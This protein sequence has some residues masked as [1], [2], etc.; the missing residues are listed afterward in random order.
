MFVTAFSYGKRNENENTIKVIKSLTMS[1]RS[2]T[3]SDRDSLT[4]RQTFCDSIYRLLCY[5]RM[6]VRVKKNLQVATLLVMFNF[7]IIDNE[8]KLLARAMQAFCFTTFNQSHFLK[9]FNS[10]C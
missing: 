4:D 8:R 7:F 5:V 9:S 6:A 2:V 1:S 3:I 10:G